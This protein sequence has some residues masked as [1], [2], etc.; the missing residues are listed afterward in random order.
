MGFSVKREGYVKATELLTALVTDMS[1]NG[2]DIRYVNGVAGSAAPSGETTVACLDAT[3][4][5]DPLAD[6]QPWSVFFTARST[7]DP[8]YKYN[9]GHQNWLRIYIVTPSQVIEDPTMWRIALKD[10]INTSSKSG[11]RTTTSSSSKPAGMLSYSCLQ[12]SASGASGGTSASTSSVTDG[13]FY[14]FNDASREN[15]SSESASANYATQPNWDKRGDFA[16]HPLSYRL[17]VSDHGIAFAMWGE[18]YDSSG[19]E[20]AWFC[21]QR[22]VDKDTGAIIEEGK[23]PLFTVFSL[24]GNKSANLDD[25][26]PDQVMYMVTRESD[27]TTPTFPRSATV[28]TADSN[29]IINA[30]QQV[31]IGE[32]E[33]FIVHFPNGL[34]SQ[35]YGYPHELDMIGYTSADAI[36]QDNEIEMT[37]YG[38]TNPRM[39]IGL[40]SNNIHNKGMRIVMQT[41]GAGVT[42]AR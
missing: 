12:R 16:A 30:V 36:S 5:V 9:S 7:E 24:E 42:I 25:A 34:N 10:Y 11:E 6:D 2:F 33:K 37:F 41:E 40:A 31:A 28:D 26:D 27:V 17:T 8:S 22:M 32:D 14:C 21:T 13:Y 23:S 38:E 35:R 18:S 3:T 19:N 29:R 4:A 15:T 20:Q 1:N 39:Y